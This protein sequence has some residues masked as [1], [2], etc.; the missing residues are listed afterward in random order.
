MLS[1]PAVE[2]VLVL[3]VAGLAGKL[4]AVSLLVGFDG[5]ALGVSAPER[6]QSLV[7]RARGPSF[8]AQRELEL[9]ALL[10]FP[11]LLPL[12]VLETLHELGGREPLC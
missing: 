11:E 4:L 6:A 10:A 1:V 8:V 12:I 7:A 2:R 9:P 5:F 3:G